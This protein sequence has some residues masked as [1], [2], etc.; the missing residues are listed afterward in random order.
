MDHSNHFQ[1]PQRS[2]T[3]IQG[4]YDELG[5]VA[6]SKFAF[7]TE[8]G[9]IIRREAHEQPISL[10]HDV[11]GELLRASKDESYL[12]L[13]PAKQAGEVR[14]V[15]TPLCQRIVNALSVDYL[16]IRLDYP[17]HRF[18]PIFKVFSSV[19]RRLLPV[20]FCSYLKRSLDKVQAD[21]LVQAA[22]VVIQTLRKRLSKTVVKD[23][24]ENFRRGAIENFNGFVDGIDWLSQ[25][26]STVTVLRFDLHFRKSGS[27]PVGNP[28]EKP[29]L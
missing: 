15:C 2:D 16:Q 18:S 29:A 17:L 25:R 26:Y 6:L 5:Q 24:Y 9:V 3:W 21:R 19:R 11:A 14:I 4:D 1:Q 7:D 28:P 27:Q 12:S 23:A 10:I 13:S 8:D 22:L 20:D